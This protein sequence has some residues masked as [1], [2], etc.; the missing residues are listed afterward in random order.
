MKFMQLAVTV[1]MASLLQSGCGRSS[2][3]S[4]YILDGGSPPAQESISMASTLRVAMVNVPDYLNRNNIVSREPG[5]NRLILADFHLWAEP[6]SNGVRRVMQGLLA[7]LLR[8]QKIDV[9]SNGSD[10][11]ADF[12][13]EL[14]IHNLD[15][16][17][18]GNATLSATWTLFGKNAAA[19]KSGEF[20]AQSP[21]PGK[22]YDMLVNAES[23]VIRA[24]AEDVA[25]SIVAAIRAYKK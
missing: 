18:G 20:V 21:V 4:Y 2:P 17:F 10:Q 23:K 6:L 13:L 24:M 9:I 5:S 8:D 11:D 25:P 1:I 15:G 22:S 12:V 14:D 7:G 3:S 16:N 19:I